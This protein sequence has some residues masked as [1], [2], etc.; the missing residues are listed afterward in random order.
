VCVHGS[1]VVISSAGTCWRLGDGGEFC[2]DLGRS[3]AP[4]GGAGYRQLFSKGVALR[5][6]SCGEREPQYDLNRKLCPGCNRA[7]LRRTLAGRRQ[8][9]GGCRSARPPHDW[10]SGAHIET[11]PAIEFARR[12][13]RQDYGE[14]FESALAR[15]AANEVFLVAPCGSPAASE[16]PGCSNVQ[17]WCISEWGRQ[18]ASAPAYPPG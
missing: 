10:W 7:G 18:I 5:K 1:V 2:A 4:F 6:K 16:F 15:A 3:A 8:P 11:A 14:E 17:V 9:F 12:V 13:C